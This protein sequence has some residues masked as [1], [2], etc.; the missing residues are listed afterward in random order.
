LLFIIFQSKATQKPF[1]IATQ[2]E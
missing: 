2:F 1:P